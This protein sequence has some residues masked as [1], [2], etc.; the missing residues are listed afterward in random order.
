MKSSLANV[1]AID[2]ERAAKRG[3]ARGRSDEAVNFG[4]ATEPEVRLPIRIE[5]VVTCCVIKPDAIT[6]L[7]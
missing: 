6:T 5:S 7:R 3:G 2:A 4:V 1:G